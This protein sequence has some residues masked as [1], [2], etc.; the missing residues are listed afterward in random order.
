MRVGLKTPA[1]SKMEIFVIIV[2]E[3]KLPKMVPNTILAKIYETS[4]SAS[5]K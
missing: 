4:F 5:V 2:K 3:W 1:T